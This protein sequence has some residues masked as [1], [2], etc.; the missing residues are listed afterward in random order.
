M[1]EVNIKMRAYPSVIE[2]VNV[3]VKDTM[4]RILVQCLD[5]NAKV[6][7]DFPPE[8]SRYYNAGFTAAIVAV[9]MCVGITDIDIHRGADGDVTD[10]TTH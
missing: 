1:A 6:T 7:A 4:A 9:A 3:A 8:K 2:A 10:V 5:V